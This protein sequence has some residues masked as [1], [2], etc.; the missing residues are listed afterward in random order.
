MNSNYNQLL[1]SIGFLEKFINYIETGFHLQ[2]EKADNK[3]DIEWF[4]HFSKKHLE[5][6]DFYCNWT[7]PTFNW[8]CYRKWRGDNDPCKEKAIIMKDEL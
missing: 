4:K 5:F 1:M 7:Y 3:K 8:K 6:M 2:F